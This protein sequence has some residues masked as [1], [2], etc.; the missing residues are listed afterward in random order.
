MSSAASETVGRV[1]A[2]IKALLLEVKN[3]AGSLP[4]VEA[5]D[6]AQIVVGCQEISRLTTAFT[7]TLRDANE[8]A[9]TNSSNNSSNNS[10][11]SKAG[12][13]FDEAMLSE[14]KER[15]QSFLALVKRFVAEDTY[16]DD[17]TNATV[18]AITAAI[19]PVIEVVNKRKTLL[20]QQ[21]QQAQH[22]GAAAA[23]SSSSD[24]HAPASYSTS[25]PIPIASAAAPAAVSA[26][27]SK[28]G[29]AS[30]AASPAT[31]ATASSP[32]DSGAD[33]A[34]DGAKKVSFARKFSRS[35]SNAKDQVLSRLKRS[36]TNEGDDPTAA[37]TG[38][39]AHSPQS[40]SPRGSAAGAGEATGGDMRDSAG[41][42]ADKPSRFRDLFRSNTT[43]S[44]SPS[45]DTSS[46]GTTDGAQSSSRADDA[47]AAAAPPN[48]PPKR[49]NSAPGGGGKPGFMEN[50]KRRFRLPQ[51]WYKF[52]LSK[53]KKEQTKKKLE[54]DLQQIDDVE[55]EPIVEQMKK[56][57]D[58]TVT[59]GD[60]GEI[61]I[62]VKTARTNLEARQSHHATT[63]AQN[64][65]ARESIVILKSMEATLAQTLRDSIVI[66]P[67]A[68]AGAAAPPSPPSARA[69]QSQ[70]P[71]PSSKPAAKSLASASGA[72]SV[73]AA[74]AT[75]SSA[76]SADDTAELDALLG[77]V[78]TTVDLVALESVLDEPTTPAA[79]VSPAAAAAASEEEQWGAIEDLLSEYA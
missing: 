33:G 63:P 1:N 40:T 56:L 60:V 64:T 26:S 35:I 36:Q 71:V 25:P 77:T 11:S 30:A 9:N 10:S 76:L 2:A 12:T 21:Q 28:D 43:A 44:A 65:K 16:D 78:D 69:Q 22:N 72:R 13:Q 67:G 39:D 51:G 31:T 55:S 8:S 50:M 34:A 14:L 54:N 37:A 47:A 42:S 53:E 48:E 23:A 41:K 29:G 18:L 52:K 75:P 58:E 17:A 4:D 3:L 74:A 5:R 68:V 46:L 70:P 66:A 32:P 73:P 6:T 15:V 79:A 49:K 38:D 62:A 57:D 61:A 7:A 24:D 27:P 45:T 19:K 59:A 20:L